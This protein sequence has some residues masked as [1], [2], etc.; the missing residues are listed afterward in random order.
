MLYI[1]NIVEHTVV[2]ALLFIIGYPLKIL[3]FVSERG[4]ILDGDAD[5]RPPGEGER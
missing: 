3:A 4:E 5:L 1:L 2:F